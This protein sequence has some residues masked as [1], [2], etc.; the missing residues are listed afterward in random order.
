[1]IVNEIKIRKAAAETEV[2]FH[3]TVIGEGAS[4]QMKKIIFYFDFFFIGTGQFWKIMMIHETVHPT[5]KSVK[6]DH[7][8]LLKIREI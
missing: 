6:Y 2:G 8:T 3:W 4:H 1:M 7:S 5:D